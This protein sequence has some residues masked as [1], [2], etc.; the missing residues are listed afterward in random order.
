MK[1]KYLLYINLFFL[2]LLNSAFSNAKFYN[3]IKIDENINIDGKI[4]EEVWDRA[5]IINDF[6]QVFPFFLNLPS[7]Q[8]D[9]KILYDDQNIY[10]GVTLYQDQETLTFKVGEYDDFY[11]TFESSSDYFIVEID[12]ENKRETS[13]GFAAN[14]SGVKSDY[15]IFDN[16]SNSIDDYWNTD[17]EVAVSYGEN[18]WIAEI[19]IPISSLRFDKS[20]KLNWG[21]NFIRYSKYNNETAL[22]SVDSEMTEK[23][24][25]Q[26][27]ELKNLK[28]K[29]KSH[30]QFKPYFWIGEIDYDDDYYNIALDQNEN[31]VISSST[32]NKLTLG[33]DKGGFDFKY[34]LKSNNTIDITY[35]PDF[36]QIEQDPSIINNTAYEIVFDEKRPFFLEHSS[37]YNTPINIFYSRRIGDE[38]IYL[39]NNNEK[40]YRTTNFSKA[41]NI[42]GDKNN[43]SYGF[44]YAESD[45]DN[46]INSKSIYGILRVKYKLPEKNSFIAF[47]NTYNDFPNLAL[48]YYEVNKVY[49]IDFLLELLNDQSFY[50]DGQFAQSNFNQTIGDGKNIEIGY[51]KFLS[52]NKNLQLWVK[53]ENYNQNFEINKIGYMMRNDLKEINTG[54]SF[55]QYGLP[56]LHESKFA[57]RYVK[58]KNYN[59]QIIQNKINFEY[60]AELLNFYKIRFVLSREYK[61]YIDRFYDYYFDIPSQ[62]STL[63]PLYKN[64]QLSISNDQRDRISY[65][66]TT[67]Y[68]K[69]NFNNTG[70]N[71]FISSKY[72]MNENVEMEIS[73]E[74]LSQ[75]SKHHFLKIKSLSDGCGGICSNHRNSYDYL[76]INSDNKE[77]YLTFRLS[78]YLNNN[79]SLQLYSEFY[80]YFND[81]DQNSQLY[82]I[83]NNN[84]YPEEIDDINLDIQEDKIIYI[85]RYSSFITNFVIKAEFNNQADIHFVYSLSKGVN[86]KIFNN[87]KDLL[88]YDNE[89]ISNDDMAE[90]FYDSSFFI[91]YNFVLK[92]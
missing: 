18:F 56:K 8:T 52:N 55:A 86:G 11:E 58:A 46:Y 7:N 74:E 92:K 72:I 59:N 6:S 42:L 3:P 65:I 87:P 50:I 30:I 69:D 35:N 44:L 88:T 77:K 38:V 79:V 66:I 17:W 34:K 28:I 49:S 14:I 80:R 15:M 85:S 76:F 27:G 25:S 22:W 51:D 84:S 13:Y 47:S 2:T 9:V 41:I 83:M 21:V 89:N 68:F 20:P 54:I 67:D 63:A 57:L 45:F 36:G 31:P 82:K 23:I 62:L 19:K 91:K 81:W 4:N 33:L 48:N 26:Y 90:I 10:F 71:Y 61:Y 78:T 32:S 16:D 40:E 37:F 70:N 43:F 53:Y 24:L 5:K 64:I 12:S 75:F 1:K 60:L 73:Y 39:N 29:K